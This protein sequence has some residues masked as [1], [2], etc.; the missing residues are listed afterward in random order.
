LLPKLFAFIEQPISKKNYL[1]H[2]EFTLIYF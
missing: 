1:P 2:S